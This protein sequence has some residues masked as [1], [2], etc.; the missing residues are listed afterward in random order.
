M[1]KTEITLNQ[2]ELEK[3]L[4]MLKDFN[5]QGDD[6]EAVKRYRTVTLIQEGDNG[7]GTTLD[8]QFYVEHKGVDGIFT[9]S[10]TGVE[11]W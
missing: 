11:D 5:T 8:A 2:Y 6:I 1:N 10:I 7:I 9:V 4:N 3:I